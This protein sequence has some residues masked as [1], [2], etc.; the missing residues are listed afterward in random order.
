[1]TGFGIY[2]DIAMREMVLKMIPRLQTCIARQMGLKFTKRWD[3]R[4][5]FNLMDE[6]QEL[7]I[8]F[9]SS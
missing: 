7:E 3:S 9:W 5:G 8:Y 4:K 1:M 2:W 6:G